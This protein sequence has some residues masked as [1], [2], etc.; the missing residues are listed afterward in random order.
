MEAVCS[1]ENNIIGGIEALAWWLWRGQIG[2]FGRRRACNGVV[3]GAGEI[4]AR[5]KK[6]DQETS[7][8]PKDRRIITHHRIFVEILALTQTPYCV[9]DLR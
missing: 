9:Q 6:S 8:R 5:S 7:I 2:K 3:L 1:A 4:F